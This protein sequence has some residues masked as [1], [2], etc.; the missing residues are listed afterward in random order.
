MEKSSFDMK[1]DWDAWAREDALWAAGDGKSLKNSFA[2][3]L[4][5]FTCLWMSCEKGAS[6]PR[7]K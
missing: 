2:R 1:H 3:G 7:E 4:A 6:V 5:R